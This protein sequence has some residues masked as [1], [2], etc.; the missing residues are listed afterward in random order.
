M[1]GGPYQYNRFDS[2]EKKLAEAS[3]PDYLDFDGDGNKKESMKKALKEKGKKKSVKKES[4]GYVRDEKEDEERDEDNQVGDGG[5][6]GDGGGAMG[7]S[8]QQVDEI[9]APL[10]AGTAGAITGKKDR[11]VKKA[12]GSGSGAAIGGMLGGPVGAVLGGLAGGAISDE[13]QHEE[14]EQI[15]EVVGMALDAAGKVAKGVA[16]VA[17]A[18]VKLAGKAVKGVTDAVTGNDKKT[19]SEMTASPRENIARRAVNK[20]PN[21]DKKANAEAAIVAEEQKMA[22]YARALGRMGSMYSGQ[23]LTEKKDDEPTA[24]RKAAADR[25]YEE[26]RQKKEGKKGEA[27]ETKEIEKLEDKDLSESDFPM[28]DAMN[29]AGMNNAP[30]RPKPNMT[31]KASA[32]KKT[33]LAAS[34]DITL[35]KA[36][37]VK[38]LVDEG[39][40]NNEVSAEILHQHVSDEFLANIEEMMTEDILNEDA[41]RTHAAIQKKFDAQNAASPGSALR[42][43]P[44]KQSTG[45]AL[46]KAGQRLRGV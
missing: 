27:H 11:K 28:R 26:K 46:Y 41:A 34:H 45:Q 19:V 23:E 21:T 24:E 15:D 9:V 1:S 32:G 37:V 38:Y 33:N 31:P 5:F 18:P 40:A 13:V 39:Y 3:K 30:R 43:A 8:V 6:T 44:G 25:G 20:M 29:A 35:T 2:F 22:R 10:I 7:E 42:A 36:D 17:T 4:R 14:G 12:V 16:D